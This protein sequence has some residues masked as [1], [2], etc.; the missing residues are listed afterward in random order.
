MERM[1]IAL[2]QRRSVLGDKDRNIAAMEKVLKEFKG[3]DIYVFPELYLTGYKIRDKV[4]EL[5][6]EINGRSVDR[7]IKL[8]EEYGVNIVFGMPERSQDYK[9][10]IYN[11][12]VFVYSDGKVHSY[13]KTYLPNFGPFEEYIYFTPNSGE[14]PIFCLNNF[15]LG[16]EICYDMFFPEI[17]KY[18]ALLGVD[19]IICISASPS[20]TRT[21]FESVVPARAI[22]NTVYVA[23]ANVVGTEHNLTFWGGDFLVSP[24]G[25]IKVKGKYFKEDVVIGEVDTKEL[26]LARRLRPTIRDTRY[27]IIKKLIE[28]W[29]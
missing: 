6:E 19:L 13:K 4:W 21:F 20:V 9:G 3:A 10:L 18:Y 12:A 5:A 7:I 26:E 23:Y 27:E 29:D 24:R 16:L 17:S 1:K 15:K 11:S 25:S 8:A 14:Y 22:E 28:V 2:C